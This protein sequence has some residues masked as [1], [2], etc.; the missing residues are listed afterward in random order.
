M[1]TMLL[2]SAVPVTLPRYVG[3]FNSLRIASVS[4][5]E[6]RGSQTGGQTSIRSAMRQDI[7]RAR[8]EL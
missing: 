5:F 4:S 8:A 2:L 7:M 3:G 1:Y 6:F